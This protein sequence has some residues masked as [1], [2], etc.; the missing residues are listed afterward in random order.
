MIKVDP[1][2]PQGVYDTLL[3]LRL[4][5]WAHEQDPEVSRR[6]IS[7]ESCHGDLKINYYYSRKLEAKIF[8]FILLNEAK[9]FEQ[10]FFVMDTGVHKYLEI[11]VCFLL[12]L[13]TTMELK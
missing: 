5:D 11:D 6:E 2:C 3:E 7:Y 8:I 13:Y 4:Q 10:T 9:S 12:P 1:H